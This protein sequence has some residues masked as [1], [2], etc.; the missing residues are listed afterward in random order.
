MKQEPFIIDLKAGTYYFCACGKS[1]NLP[2]CD[3]SH[4]VTDSV[5]YPVEIKEA[6][7]VG[8]CRCG[9]SKT[10]PFCDGTHSSLA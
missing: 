8:I 10:K 6:R 3:G 5:P 9:Q 7:Q 1:G 2:Y 4:Q